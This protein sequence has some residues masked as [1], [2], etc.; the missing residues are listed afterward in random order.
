MT[1]ERLYYRKMKAHELNLKLNT[2]KIIEMF[3]SK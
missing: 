2:K 1:T 3:E